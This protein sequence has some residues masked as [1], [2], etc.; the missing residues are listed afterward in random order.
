MAS[1]PPPAGAHHDPAA[2]AQSLGV[3]LG[4]TLAELEAIPVH[5]LLDQRYQ[6]FRRMGQF[7]EETR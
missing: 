6:K 1:A 2:A 3:V 5:D 4:I 7:F